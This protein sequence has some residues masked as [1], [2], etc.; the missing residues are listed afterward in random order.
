[1]LTCGWVAD[2][3]ARAVD[4]EDEEAV[5]GGLHTEGPVEGAKS[6]DGL[7]L[8]VGGE[9]C[10]VFQ[11]NDVYGHAVE[12]SDVLV[13]AERGEGGLA[14]MVCKEEAAGG[15][16]ATPGGADGAAAEEVFGG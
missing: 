14:A 4:G 7:Q 11:G 3:Q 2:A 15:G 10:L 5:A 13:A 8:A 6:H 12:V 9:H 16:G 1:V